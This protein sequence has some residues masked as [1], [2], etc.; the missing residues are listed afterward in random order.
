MS[1]STKS[2]KG[3]AAGA[4]AGVP[5]SREGWFTPG[6]IL[7]PV[8]LLGILWCLYFFY[9]DLNRGLTKLNE[10]PIALISFK[11]KAAQRRFID[12]RLWDRLRQNSPVYSGDLIRTADLSDATVHFPEGAE[13]SLGENSIIQVFPGRVDLTQGVLS[14]ADNGSGGGIIITSG[15]KTLDSPPGQAVGA[16]GEGGETPGAI[17]ALRPPPGATYLAGGSAPVRFGWET[18]GDAPGPSRLE[19]AADRDFTRAVTTLNGEGG[20]AV[21]ALGTGVWWW[22]VTGGAEGAASP[23][24]K[25]AVVNAQPPEPVAP[26]EGTIFRYRSR[27]PEIRLVWTGT[28]EASAYLVEVAA[29]PDFAEARI[30]AQARLTS[31][32]CTGLEEGT[33]YWRARPVFSG[34][35]AGTV[36]GSRVSSFSVARESGTPPAPVLGGAGNDGVITLDG[37]EGNN[38]LTWRRDPEAAGYTVYISRN[39]D[40]SD[41]LVV[42]TAANNYYTFNP[43]KNAAGPGVYYWAVTETD[44]GGGA[45]PRSAVASFTVRAGTDAPPARAAPPPPSPAPSPPPALAAAAPPAEPS[46]PPPPRPAAPPPPAPAKPEPRPEPPPPPPLAAP[47]GLV[48]NNAVFTPAELVTME[49]LEFT[50]N[51]VEGADAYLLTLFQR[52]QDGSTKRILRTGP[53]KWTTQKVDL[54]RLDEGTFEWSLEAVHL[55]PDGTVDRHG[56][57]AE[58][59]FTIKLP[60]VEELDTYDFGTLYGW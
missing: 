33:W 12:R 54:R 43:G 36:D 37:A 46:L 6:L 19:I 27:L 59:V 21:A 24:M 10:Q 28:A 58:G 11:R 45:S 41:P 40:L 55:L 42:E 47:G 57:P 53:L 16:A 60:P 9:V 26:G 8:C 23:A 56:N 52:T 50:W 15:G 30:R 1:E 4:G 17:R 35:F 25:V 14:L 29:S 39:A 49:Q 22:R 51:P 34:N 20:E 44:A 7:F 32:V 13:I 48:P 31:F 2:A 38:Y 18:P 3:P 5:P